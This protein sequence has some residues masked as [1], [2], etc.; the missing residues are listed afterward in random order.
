MQLGVLV[1]SYFWK[2]LTFEDVSFCIFQWGDR[3]IRQLVTIHTHIYIYMYVYIYILILFN[4]HVYKY[5]TIYFILLYSLV[6]ESTWE[7]IS[8]DSVFKVWSTDQL[9]QHHLRT[10]L[11]CTA[12]V[13]ELWGCAQSSVFFPEH[14]W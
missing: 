5:V 11:K 10:R 3:E 12:I 6:F 13:S 1:S 14:S 8:L 7:T 4:F 9:H 2:D